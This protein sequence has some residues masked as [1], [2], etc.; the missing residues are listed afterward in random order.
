M[1]AGLATR[2]ELMCWLAGNNTSKHSVPDMV[3][4]IP[5]LDGRCSLLLLELKYAQDTLRQAQLDKAR[6][7]HLDLI[8]AIR[9][10]PDQR[11]QAGHSST[12]RL[13]GLVLDR[14]NITCAPVILGIGGTIFNDTMDA[15]SRAGLD[16][17]RCKKLANKLNLLA[18]EHAA[19]ITGIRR[20]LENGGNPTTQPSQGPPRRGKR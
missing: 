17:T 20:A 11:P 14:K 10:T 1:Q 7:Q 18:A 6:T 19:T 8:R 2:T 16:S 15:F 5:Q 13:N 9:T 12:H 3:L 4:A